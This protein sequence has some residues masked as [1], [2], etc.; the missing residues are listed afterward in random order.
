M[1]H[2]YT[3]G[4]YASIW[5]FKLTLM[6]SFIFLEPLETTNTKH[7]IVKIIVIIRKKKSKHSSHGFSLKPQTFSWVEGQRNYQPISI[8]SINC[9]SAWFRTFPGQ[10]PEVKSFHPIDVLLLFRF[11]QVKWRRFQLEVTNT[12]VNAMKSSCFQAKLRW[13][14]LVE[15]LYKI[16]GFSPTY[17]LCWLRIWNHF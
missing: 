16:R 11:Q 4:F 15:W 10:F 17:D 5:F 12:A 2:V 1:W 6:D 9:Y 7:F 13:H 14:F 8:C 3:D